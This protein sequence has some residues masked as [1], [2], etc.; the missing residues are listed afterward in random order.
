[1]K[2][3]GVFR[4]KAIK[5]ILMTIAV[6]GLFAVLLGLICFKIAV[7]DVNSGVFTA[8]PSSELAGEFVKGVLFNNEY[9]IS[10]Q[11]LNSFA[12]YLIEQNAAAAEQDEDRFSVTDFYI[13]LRSGGVGRCYI[14]IKNSSLAFDI[15]ADCRSKLENN[16][17]V[18]SFDNASVGNL[19]IPNG[20]LS[21][22]LKRTDLKL[23]SAFIDADDLE[24]HLPSHYG[25]TI[26]DYGE[27]VSIDITS[28][29]PNDNGITVSTNPV[30]SDALK[31]VLHI[32]ID[33]IVELA[34]EMFK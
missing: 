19:P 34:P 1:M 27:A 6:I 31:N 20:V 7:A 32:F 5:N 33:K 16:E 14:R 26:P 29:S 24:L 22:F 12:A 28:L 21:Y 11:E 2:H 30:V 9:E 18:I 10:E 17:I 23:A 15:S 3:S 25:L 8:E 13:D 4:I